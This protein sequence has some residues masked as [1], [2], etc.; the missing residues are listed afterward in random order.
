MPSRDGDDSLGCLQSE[1]RRSFLLRDKMDEE[2]RG[3]RRK[4]VEAREGVTSRYFRF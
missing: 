4:R 3:K 1:R 2:K